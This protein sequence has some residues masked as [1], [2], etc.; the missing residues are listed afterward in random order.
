MQ[1]A[2]Q[3]IEEAVDRRPDFG[4]PVGRQQPFHQLDM[5]L[6]EGF[7]LIQIAVVPGCRQAAQPDQGVGA[8]ADGRA[9][10][11]GAVAFERRTDDIDNFI[12][13]C[14]GGAAEFEYLHTQV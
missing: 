12:R 5:P 7:Q 13:R 9:D 2:L 11:D 8:A 4:Q 14:D 10:Q 1:D 3:G 6:V